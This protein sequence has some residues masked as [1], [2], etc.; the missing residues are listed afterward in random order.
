M[1][2][3]YGLDFCGGLNWNKGERERESDRRMIMV[4][5]ESDK[6]VSI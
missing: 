1:A 6:K 3:E 2:S 5:G 4:T